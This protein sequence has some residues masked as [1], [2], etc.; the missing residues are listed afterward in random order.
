MHPPAFRPIAPVFA[1]FIA[2]LFAL[3]PLD[4]PAQGTFPASAVILQYHHVSTTTPRVTSVNADEFRQHLEYLRD[5]GFT[6]L[7]LEDIVRT[8]REGGVLPDRAAAIT[9]DDGYLN[10]YTTAYPILREFGWPFTLFISAGLA[11]TN[12]ALYMNWDQLREMAAHGATIANHGVE[13]SYLLERN[14]GEDAAAWLRR[15]EQEILAAEA[16]IEQQTGTSHRLFAYP[17]GEYDR[18]I[19]TLVARL[20]F[21]GIG[22]QS[23]PVNASSDFTALPRFPFSGSYAA[24]NT[25]A[26]KVQSLAF[27]VKLLSPDSPVTN[28]QLPEAVLD[29]DGDYRFDALNCFNDNH[30]MQVEAEDMAEQRYR[31]RPLAANTTRRFRYNCTAPAREGRFYW[32]SI[33]WVNPALASDY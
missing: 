25:F 33:P 30:P 13:H 18:V 28:M 22:Q 4:A 31:I 11:G 14:T 6:V 10:N 21:V 17:F 23:G 19:Q 1:L 7:R 2:C 24:M 20:G 16:E 15:V 27:D 29:F 8:L 32:Y 26:T 5:E 9:F 3:V 12:D